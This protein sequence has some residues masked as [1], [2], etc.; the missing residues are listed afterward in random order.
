MHSL[1]VINELINYPIQHH[2]I[3]ALMP[4]GNAVMLATISRV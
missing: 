1:E 2:S 4:H 3:K